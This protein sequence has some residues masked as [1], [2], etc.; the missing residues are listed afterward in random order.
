MAADAVG[1]C[2]A[3]HLDRLHL[4]GEAATF[5]LGNFLNGHAQVEPGINPLGLLVW[6]LHHRGIKQIS[7]EV[8]A[9]FL[10]DKRAEAR[11]L[12]QVYNYKAHYSL[13][14]DNGIEKAVGFCNTLR[15]SV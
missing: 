14:C 12:R 6:Q 4:Q 13:D 8:Q 5:H 7:D 1:P 10:A 15:H 2:A 11:Y 9:V 3:D